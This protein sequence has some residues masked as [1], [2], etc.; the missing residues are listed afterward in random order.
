[1]DRIDA[2]LRA[3]TD[4]GHV[5]GV[6][7]MATS[8]DRTLY[9][10]AFGV[11]DLSA[12]AAMTEDTVFWI[13]SMTKALVSVAAMQLIEQ[14]RMGLDQDSGSLVPGLADLQ[15]LEGFA[16]DGSPRLR[17]ARG[18]VTIRHLLTHTAGF[19]YD[20]LN[21]RTGLY[22]KAMNVPPGPSGLRAS[23]AT[24]LAFD[25]G[26]RWEYG[27]NIDW[28][29]QV[30]E[31][32][33]GQ[34]LDVYL[35][36]HVTGPLGM[37]DTGFVLESGHRA[38]LARTHMRTGGVLAP[39]DFA[40]N[41]APEFFSGGGGLYGTAPDYLRFIAAFLAGGAPVLGPR[42]VALMSQN[43]VGD[44]PAGLMGDAAM[45]QLT[46]SVDYFPGSVSKWGFGFLINTVQLPGGRSVGS[47]TWA[48]LANTYYW[49]DPARGVGGVI[50]MQMLPFGDPE[51]LKLLAGFEQAVY[52]AL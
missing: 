50:M 10:G 26:E 11:R 40:T 25:P 9:H 38:R 27:I 24:P 43:Q 52:A 30:I 18:P 45:P 8:A 7:A 35:R 23:L 29:G 5:P 6:V 31:A 28:L 39:I 37:T 21:A 22:M 49:I 36:Q 16:D 51:A 48:G 15:V 4:A 17:P 33:S 32:V 14:G 41:Q 13:A 19:T 42:S 3:A 20:F 46:N 1:M 44:L 2:L 12:G 34:T 47:L